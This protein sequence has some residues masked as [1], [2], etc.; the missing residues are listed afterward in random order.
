MDTVEANL[1]LGF[2][3][4]PRD[5]GIAAQI[6]AALGVGPIRLLTNNP[7]KASGL[8]RY[9]VEV[10]EELPLIL[11]PHPESTAYLR[12]KRDKLGH[13]LALTP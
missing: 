1:A 2:A 4:D 10:A 9:G 6:L 13:R 5:Y 7:M 3:A 8:Q 11:S 12:A